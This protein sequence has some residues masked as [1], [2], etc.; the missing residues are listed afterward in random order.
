MKPSE[1]D[2]TLARWRLASVSSSRIC[3]SRVVA[4]T[5][6]C[7]M[8]DAMT[9][10]IW[11]DPKRYLWAIALT[12]PLLPWLAL[13]LH[14]ASG[15][16]LWLWLGPIVTLGVVPLLDVITG[17]D[18]ANPPAE[19]TAALEA[20]R[21]YRWVTYLFLP[22]QYAGFVAAFYVIARGD[23]SVAECIGL[24][25]TV[26]FIGGLGINTAHELGH[27]KE[28]VERWLSKIALAQSW[29][30][31]FYIE[32]NRGH[33]VRVATP[34]DPASSRLG[35]SFY[36]FWP[37]T[38]V[39]SLRSAWQLEA[40]RYAR[41]GQHPFRPGNNV[42]NAWLL[43]AVLW[44]VM[45]L[46]LG[47][48][49]LPYLVLQGVIGLTLLEAVNY[50]EHYGLLRQRVGAP[51]R[52]RYE[53]VAPRHSW[54]SNH[55]TTNVLLYHLQRHSDHHAHPTRR[56]QA[57][58]DHAEAPVLPTGYAGM[59]LLA[60]VPPLWYR[61][62]DPR[63]LAHYGGDVRLANVA[64]HAQARLLARYPA[65]S[66]STAIHSSS[67][68]QHDGNTAPAT[69]AADAYSCPGCGYTYAP[70]RGAPREGYPAGTPWADLPGDWPCPDCGVREK[71]DFV[72]VSVAI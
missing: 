5:L 29:Y 28:S 7:G 64:P 45:V 67:G 57:L 37:R 20:D 68:P 40:R 12:M 6:H 35:E 15:A 10:A 36:R 59:I 61:V 41:I 4:V 56:Y 53:H 30:G 23:L 42:L 46:W 8:F 66:H 33:H 34:D 3:G 49:I 48:E 17:V 11:Q 19:L 24:S 27:K 1:N 13:G 50:L 70:R 47:V 52:E 2:E 69:F 31:H 14:A 58:R 44:T 22:L 16:G 21:Y 9:P 18:R 71:T 26:G 38:V 54:N 60:L 65:P 55:L 72:P 43:S 32:H 39:G 25:A 63:V 62:V 51:G